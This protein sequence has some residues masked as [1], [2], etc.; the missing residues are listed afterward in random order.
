MTNPQ[1]FTI[2]TD[3]AILSLVN[4]H[5]VE[6]WF[7]SAVGKDGEELPTYS[8]NAY[9]PRYGFRA[10]INSAKRGAEGRIAAVRVVVRYTD[11]TIS[12]PLF[13]RSSV[14]DGTCFDDRAW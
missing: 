6:T 9:D 10:A 7:I 13:A 11:G 14:N 5:D 8:S 1:T 12:A 4:A 3:A 2:A